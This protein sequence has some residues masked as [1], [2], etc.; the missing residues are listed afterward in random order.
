MTALDHVRVLATFGTL[1]LLAGC[2]ATPA[3]SGDSAAGHPEA[4]EAI[5]G[6]LDA[7]HGA[8]ARAD[9]TAYFALLAPD[10]VFLG[11]DATERWAKEEFRAY[12][13]PYFSQGKG[14]TYLPRERSI[15]LNA[16]A[17]A[18]WFDERLSNEKYGECRGTGALVLR[19]GRWLIV[20]YNLSVP[21][22]NELL[23]A[24]AD[25]IRARPGSSR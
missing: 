19:D 24:F 11:T 4:R 20:Q 5:D 21:I 13:M 3:R 17:D 6:V 12:A 15:S 10:A 18:A 22:P 7:F 8:A 9:G 23:P 16:D 14:W 25:Q 2:S 1:L